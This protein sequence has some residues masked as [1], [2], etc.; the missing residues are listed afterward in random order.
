MWIGTVTTVAEQMMYA[1]KQ[2]LKAFKEIKDIAFD[3]GNAIMADNVIVPEEREVFIQNCK[4][5]K[6]YLP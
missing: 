3:D 4:L 1:D 6:S 5:E 2:E